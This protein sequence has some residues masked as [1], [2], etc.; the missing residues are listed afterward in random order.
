MKVR[1][2]D[3]DFADVD[4]IW[5]DDVA[6]V[7][8]INAQG[9][10]PAYIEPFLIKVMR[11]AKAELDPVE[12]AGLVR[13]IDVFNKQEAQ[14]FK[15]HAALNRCVR[16][17]GY[18]GMADYERSYEAEYDEML[19][20]RPL[21]WLLAYCE[22]FESMGLAA[23]PM[24]V[25]GGLEASLPGADPRVLA[26][27]KWHLAEEYE[28]RTVAF[29]VLKAL[30]GRNALEFYV[31]RVSGFLHAT[32]HIGRNVAAL[33]QYL[34]ANAP[35]AGV[36]PT[37]RWQTVLAMRGRLRGFGHV[38]SPFYDPARVP[39]PVHLAEVLRSV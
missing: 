26:L 33:Q 39:P 12:H 30:Y 16:E 34:M 6:A 22:G 3:F 35:R 23:A 32:R 18:E 31:L 38:L 9:I 14:H 36:A 20:R 8:G 13:D 28:H 17:H 37:S 11:R 29:R 4:P 15:F 1:Q 25:D 2:P 21:K 7:H 5:A 10:V 24:F 27:W 19:A